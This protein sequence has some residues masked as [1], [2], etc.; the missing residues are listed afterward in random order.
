MREVHDAHDAEDQCK[1]NSEQ[2]VCAAENER[3]DDVLQKFDHR[4]VRAPFDPG[5]SPSFSKILADAVSAAPALLLFQ[6]RQDDFAVLD[7]DQVNV[8]HALAA[9]LAFRA[10]LLEFDFSVE[11]REV[12]L[13]KRGTDRFRFGLAGL[14]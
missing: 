11:A 10:L 12:Y 13:P 8:R 5:P 7:L 3:I 4:S 6:L 9:F 1:A 14:L 2:R